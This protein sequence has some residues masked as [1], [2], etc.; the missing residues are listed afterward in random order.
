[1]LKTEKGSAFFLEE[2]K[3]KEFGEEGE[4]AFEELRTNIKRKEGLRRR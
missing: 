1:M 4:G 2:K 3:A